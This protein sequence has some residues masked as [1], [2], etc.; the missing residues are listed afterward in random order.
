MDCHLFLLSPLHQHNMYFNK[1]YKNMYQQVIVNLL[2]YP[3]VV[4]NGNIHWPPGYGVSP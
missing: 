3:H 1:S 2:L 4:I